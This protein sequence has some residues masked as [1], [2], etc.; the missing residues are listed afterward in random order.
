MS[1]NNHE[2]TLSLDLGVTNKFQQGGEFANM[3]SMNDENT[4]YYILRK[5]PPTSLFLSHL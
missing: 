3:E 1:M 4:L 5:T 2:S